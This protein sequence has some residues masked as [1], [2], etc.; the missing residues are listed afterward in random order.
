[1]HIYIYIY[2]YIYIS[3]FIHIYIY[4]HIYV[5]IYTYIYLYM[6]TWPPNAGNVWWRFMSAWK[7]MQAIGSSCK[8]WKSAKVTLQTGSQLAMILSA[9]TPSSKRK[10][11]CFSS[12][13]DAG[14]DRSRSA[15]V[16]LVDAWEGR[17]FPFVES[18]FQSRLKKPNAPVSVSS[19]W[20]SGNFESDDKH[21]DMRCP[22]W[23]KNKN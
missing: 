1:M 8:P 5:N 19:G 23:H 18:A 22:V 17:K 15:K 9:S 16:I 13:Y 20:A 3:M 10:A 21:V 14:A 6:N 2:T 4:I 12:R 7:T 11:F